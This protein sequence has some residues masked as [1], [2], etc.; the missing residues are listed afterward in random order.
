MA[1]WHRIIET[2]AYLKR[3]KTFLTIAE[4]EEIALTLACNPLAG[5]VVPGGHGIR[6]FRHAIGTRGKSGGARVIYYFHD[7]RHPLLLL[8]VF[9]KNERSDLSRAELSE[10]GQ[11]TRRLKQGLRHS[12]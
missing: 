11:L 7:S 8:T 4:Q 3:A 1:G 9:A 2:P 10:L 5:A 6:K 12:R